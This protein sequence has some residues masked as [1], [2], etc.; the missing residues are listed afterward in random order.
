MQDSIVVV[1]SHLIISSASYSGADRIFFDI[2]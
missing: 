2:A 1:Y